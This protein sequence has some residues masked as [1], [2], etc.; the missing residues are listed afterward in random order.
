MRS[1]RFTAVAVVIAALLTACGSSDGGGSG[2]PGL[3]ARQLADQ[4]K[5]AGLP[6]GDITVFDEASDPNNQLGRPGQY[7][8]K[9]G[10]V[11]TR[12]KA[13]DAQDTPGDISRG[14]GIEVWPDKS[15][16]DTR[17]KYIR[18]VTEAMSIP[19]LKEYDYVS[20]GYLLRLTFNLTPDQAKQYEGEFRRIT[21]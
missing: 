5:A 1:A 20:G 8:S 18:T 4:L 16:A 9:A 14:G 15:K 13:E 2:K 12:V 3:S 17:A 7:T 19:S 10:W 21:A 6:I 11:D